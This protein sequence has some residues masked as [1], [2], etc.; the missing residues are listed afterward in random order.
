MGLEFLIPERDK[1]REYLLE[2]LEQRTKATTTKTVPDK[3]LQCWAQ[4]HRR[5]AGKLVRLT[6]EQQTHPW[7][8]EGNEESTG[9]QESQQKS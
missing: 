7:P 4:T 5:R 8:R 6:T 3:S 1:A 2:S 9:T